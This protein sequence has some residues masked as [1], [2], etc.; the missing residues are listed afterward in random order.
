M[1]FAALDLPSCSLSAVSFC[2]G[3]LHG[4]NSSLQSLQRSP[5]VLLRPSA[6]PCGKLSLRSSLVIDLFSFRPHATADFY[7]SPAINSVTALLLVRWRHLTNAFTPKGY[8]HCV[9]QSLKSSRLRR[10]A[11]LRDLIFIYGILN[12]DFRE[13]SLICIFI[14]TL[15]F[16][17]FDCHCF[18][19]SI[20]YFE[21]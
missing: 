1:M 9:Q 21:I 14:Y 19:S 16:G 20:S 2:S 17:E 10:L 7:C 11:V 6:Q 5:T 12:W 18:K 8:H 15:N 13:N 3:D 4:L